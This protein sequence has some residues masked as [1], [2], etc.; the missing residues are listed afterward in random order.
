MLTGKITA[1]GMDSDRHMSCWVCTNTR[2]ITINTLLP[3][4]EPFTITLKSLFL[5]PLML[6][7]AFLRPSLTTPYFPPNLSRFIEWIILK[8]LW[9]PSLA[10]SSHMLRGDGQVSSLFPCS[11]FSFLRPSFLSSPL[12]CHKGVD[13]RSTL[14]WSLLNSI[15]IS[16]TLIV[17]YR[18][19]SYP[20]FSA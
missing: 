1:R 19:P 15:Q 11:I 5:M 13:M 17:A 3:C 12:Y 16:N 20:A 6:S 4:G 2:S 9:R 7:S 10:G 18:E 8:T 14:H